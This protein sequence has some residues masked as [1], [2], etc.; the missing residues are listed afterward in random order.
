MLFIQLA[1]ELDWLTSLIS[2]CWPR[3]VLVPGGVTVRLGL[4]QAGA[5]C[6][7]SGGGS[8]GGR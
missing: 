2:A 7:G 5:A 4:L 6:G 1:C 8:G 3:P